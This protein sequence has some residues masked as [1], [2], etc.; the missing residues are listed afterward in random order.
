[1]AHAIWHI[2]PSFYKKYWADKLKSGALAAQE[3]VI[4]PMLDRMVGTAPGIPARPFFGGESGRPSAQPTRPSTPTGPRS[5]ADIVRNVTPASLGFPTPSAAA[6]TAAPPTIPGLSQRE[7]AIAAQ[8]RASSMANGRSTGMNL[9]TTPADPAFIKMM[10]AQPNPYE[11]SGPLT[12]VPSRV[13]SP[14]ASTADEYLLKQTLPRVSYSGAGGSGPGG[15]PPS[16]RETGAHAQLSPPTGPK[17]KA[18]PGLGRPPRPVGP[19]KK[20][21]A[22]AASDTGPAATEQDKLRRMLKMMFLSD[23]IKGTEAPNPDYYSAVSVGPASRAFAPLPS[24]FRG[25]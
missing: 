15:L 21:I 11:P 12:S 18:T 25:R 24:M 10:Q 13:Q 20:E 14:A 2:E 8:V 19:F 23:L 4:D 16:Q 22:E 7:Q 3:G 1:M 9:A 17:T 5:V 6:P